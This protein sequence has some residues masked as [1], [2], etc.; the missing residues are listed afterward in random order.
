M[1]I[2]KK[3]ARDRR[4]RHTP[5]TYRY[6]ECHGLGLPGLRAYRTRMRRDLLRQHEAMPARVAAMAELV[7]EVTEEYE[8]AL[9]RHDRGGDKR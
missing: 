3:R 8:Q 5:G 9:I 2:E 1:N 6:K 7:R 4:N